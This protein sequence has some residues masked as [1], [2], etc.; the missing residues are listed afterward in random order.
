MAGSRS[1]S[2][3][4]NALDGPSLDL[5]CEPPKQS[6]PSPK[7]KPAFVNSRESLSVERVP[8]CRGS[9]EAL[10]LTFDNLA[11]QYIKV[12]LSSSAV[13]LKIAEGTWPGREHLFPALA[14]AKVVP[15]GWRR[16]YS[17]HAKVQDTGPDP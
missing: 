4:R 6:E 10:V 7:P 14:S 16:V 9:S 1:S 5:G 15:D 2:T 8:M 11:R 13:T 3:K 17:S 12:E